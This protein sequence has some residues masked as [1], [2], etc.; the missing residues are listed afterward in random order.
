[1]LLSHWVPKQH[2]NIVGKCTDS[3]TE[4]SFMPAILKHNL[5]IILIIKLVEETLF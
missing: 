5:M 3:Q 2:D 1:M 4:G